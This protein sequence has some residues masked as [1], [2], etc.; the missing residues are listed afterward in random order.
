MSKIVPPKFTELTISEEK[1]V[2]ELMTSLGLKEV[3]K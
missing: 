3:E 2:R 1:L